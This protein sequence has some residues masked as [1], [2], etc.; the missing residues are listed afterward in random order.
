MLKYIFEEFFLKGNLQKIKKLQTSKNIY[1]KEF[2]A[3][4]I[5]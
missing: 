2:A 3:F 4:F 5:V 1:S